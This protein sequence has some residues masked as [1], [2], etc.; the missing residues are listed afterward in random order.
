MYV[1]NKFKNIGMLASLGL[2]ISTGMAFAAE[3]P[4]L[5]SGDTAWVL[6]S[7]VL[8]LMMTILGLA[9]SYG[10]MYVGRMFSPQSCK[11]LH[12]LFDDGSLGGHRLFIG[13]FQWGKCQ[14]TCRWPQQYVPEPNETRYG[15]LHH[16]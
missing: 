4:T 13:I 12:D 1:L 10:G 8:V 2:L 7:T 3:K 9:L 5:D 6:T 11:V 14:C 15:V 16:S